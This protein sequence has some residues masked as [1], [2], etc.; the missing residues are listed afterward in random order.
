MMFPMHDAPARR[1]LSRAI[2]LARW[3]GDPLVRID[4]L[5]RSLALGAQAFGALIPLVILIQVVEPGSDSIATDLIE[6]FDLEG[7]AAETVQQAFAVTDDETTIT[8]LSTTVLI[9]SVLSFTRR[10]Q[11]LYEATW[12]LESR[13]VRGTGWGLAWI[14]FFAL[15][16]SLYPALDGIVD[17]VVS[18]VLSLTGLFLV[19][20]L[21]PYL[22]LGRRLPWRR[23]VLQASLTAAGLVALGI[24]SALYMPRAIESSASAYGAIGVAFAMLTWLW[25]YGIV[26]VVAA[27]Y[28]SPQLGKLGRTAAGPEP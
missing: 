7:E 24:W 1:L 25:G 13:G 19:G 5:D 16:G 28:G 15:Y 27:V 22:L 20:L 4:F 2:G 21:T 12:E 18:V 11:R 9:V 23:L 6:R 14:A 17:G 10:L 26:L 8:A 3:L